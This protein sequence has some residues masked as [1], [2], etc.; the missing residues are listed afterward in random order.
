MMNNSY[1]GMLAKVRKATD[2]D[3]DDDAADVHHPPSCIV[4]KKS[5]LEYE[6]TIG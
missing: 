5:Q 1:A 6:M 2:D 4:D 3:N